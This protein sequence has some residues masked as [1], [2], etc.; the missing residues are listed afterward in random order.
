MLHFIRLYLNI[1]AILVRK[2]CM[3]NMCYVNCDKL[4]L[5]RKYNAP[6]QSLTTFEHCLIPFCL[7]PNVSVDVAYHT[8][9]YVMLSFVQREGDPYCHKP[10]YASLFGPGGKLANQSVFI[11]LFQK[12]RLWF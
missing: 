11:C 3:I 5:V 10:C 4:S 2:T 6:C 1:Y 7:V 12:P 9:V 8:L